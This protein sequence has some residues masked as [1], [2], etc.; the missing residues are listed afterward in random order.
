ML[1]QSLLILRKNSI[2]T[3][4]DLNKTDPDLK[5]EGVTLNKINSSMSTMM[6]SECFSEELLFIK[7]EEEETSER[8]P[9][10]T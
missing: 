10:L 2:M 8:I 6:S 1:T 7:V 9:F 3:S 5:T 4:L